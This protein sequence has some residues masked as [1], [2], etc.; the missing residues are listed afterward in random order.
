MRKR[1]VVKYGGTYL[2]KLVPQDLSDLN[3]KENDEVDIDDLTKI[4]NG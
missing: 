3:L 4:K 1:K 2:I